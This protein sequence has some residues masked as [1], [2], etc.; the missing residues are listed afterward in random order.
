[1][2]PEI[3]Q[4]GEWWR[5][6]PYSEKRRIWGEIVG[7]TDIQDKPSILDKPDT[8]WDRM[9]V[10]SWIAISGYWKERVSKGE[11]ER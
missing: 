2:D 8:P 9:T 5:S 6:L 1:M 4:A 10:K 3:D 7:R 11:S